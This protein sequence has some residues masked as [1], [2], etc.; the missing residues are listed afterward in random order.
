MIPS[1]HLTKFPHLSLMQLEIHLAQIQLLSDNLYQIA[2]LRTIFTSIISVFMMQ[3][4]KDE[5]FLSHI[6]HNLMSKSKGV[7]ELCF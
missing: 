6:I 3:L 7:T 2:I 4:V 1:N 5:V